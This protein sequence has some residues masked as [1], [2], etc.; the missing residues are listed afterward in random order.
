MAEYLVE[1][2]ELLMKIKNL[3]SASPNCL[4]EGDSIK[5]GIELLFALIEKQ[6]KQLSGDIGEVKFLAKVIDE[7]TICFIDL[8][9]VKC[10]EQF[11]HGN[12]KLKDME[13]ILTS[14]FLALKA[15]AL[16]KA[17]LE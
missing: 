9:K 13:P 6:E 3:L 14:L 11:Q 7:S 8:V 5:K 1:R 15:L 17:I 10:N 4:Q 12:Q 2:K 16:K